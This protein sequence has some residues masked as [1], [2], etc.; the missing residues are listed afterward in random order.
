MRMTQIYY[1]IWNNI[2]LRKTFLT[3]KNIK[4]IRSTIYL[5]FQI[6]IE[7]I[8]W[9]E[10]VV[11]V[12]GNT[13]G[14]YWFAVVPTYVNVKDTVIDQSGTWLFFVIYSPMYLII[15]LGC[16]NPW[17][18]SY[19]NRIRQSRPPSKMAA[20]TINNNFFKCPRLLTLLTLIELVEI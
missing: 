4:A 7:R 16:D 2:D 17:S 8:T 14:I 18:V 13:F 12:K 5:S 9:H 1:Q 15:V 11:D 6:T 20:V 3:S 10:C 19:Q